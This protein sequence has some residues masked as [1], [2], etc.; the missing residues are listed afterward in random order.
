[1]IAVIFSFFFIS[2]SFFLLAQ[3]ALQNGFLD[4]QRIPF[5]F[6]L[7]LEFLNTTAATATAW[8]A[9]SCIN[10]HA[11]MIHINIIIIIAS[12]IPSSCVSDT[13]C[14]LLLLS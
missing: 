12:D 9:F 6:E 2:F 14:I 11:V 5:E 1:M 7:F 10:I 13:S 4:Y 3:I 8:T